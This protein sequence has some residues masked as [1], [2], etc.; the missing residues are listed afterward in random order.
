MNVKKIRMVIDE[1][2]QQKRRT[3]QYIMDRVT[4]MKLELMS[5]NIPVE[6]D[7]VDKLEW[8]SYLR[9]LRYDYYT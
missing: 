6:Q 4:M 3:M 8:V 1:Q 2:T 9:E 5:T 7:N